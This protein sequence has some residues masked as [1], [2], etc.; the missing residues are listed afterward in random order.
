[1]ESETSILNDVKL[2]LGIDPYDEAFDIPIID[3]I[4]AT[5]MILWQL[6]VGKV[7][8]IESAEDTW[9]SYLGTHEDLGAVKPYIYM[10]VR[11][12][13]DPPQNGTLLDSLK[14]QI[15]EFEWRLNAAVDASTTFQE[16]TTSE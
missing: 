4:N 3:D 9:S 16:D 2:H 13:F 15:A 14:N 12:M 1:M 5:F 8:F 6:G 10:R 7:F 11:L